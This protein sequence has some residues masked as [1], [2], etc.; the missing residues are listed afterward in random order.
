MSCSSTATKER[1]DAKPMQGHEAAGYSFV[2]RYKGN[3]EDDF[4]GIP[5]SE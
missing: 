5:A 1:A 4:V 2:L 3:L